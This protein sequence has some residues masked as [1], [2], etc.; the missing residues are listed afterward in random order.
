MVKKSQ[1]DKVLRKVSKAIRLTKKELKTIFPT[2]AQAMACL[3]KSLDNPRN[4]RKMLDESNV[5]DSF[6]KAILKVMKDKPLSDDLKELF[7]ESLRFQMAEV[8]KFLES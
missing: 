2:E 7:R 3:N 6:R 5:P 4:F 8:R 1:A